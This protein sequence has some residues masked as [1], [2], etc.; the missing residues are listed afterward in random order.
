[1][2]QPPEPPRFLHHCIIQSPVEPLATYELCVTGPDQSQGQAELAD[3]VFKAFQHHSG[4]Q[5]RDDDHLCYVAFA[6]HP[7]GSVAWEACKRCNELLA[8]GKDADHISY[9]FTADMIGV[10]VYHDGRRIG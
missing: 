9:M 6:V 10:Q 8:E 4:Q 3:A 2:P 5:L 7:D 1:M